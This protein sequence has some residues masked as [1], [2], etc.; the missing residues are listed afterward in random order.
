MAVGPTI[1]AELAAKMNGAIEDTPL[2]Q[3]KLELSSI[4]GNMGRRLI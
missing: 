3:L 1:G 2:T 4:Q